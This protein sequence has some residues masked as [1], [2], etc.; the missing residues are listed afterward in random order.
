[1]PGQTSTLLVALT[2]TL[3]GEVA[4]ANYTADAC[5]SV[6]IDEIYIESGLY[7]SSNI[8]IQT[9]GT[10]TNPNCTPNSGVFLRLSDGMAQ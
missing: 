5:S 1:M 9:S 7:S 6:L 10:E 2:V 8:W 4:Y 3:L